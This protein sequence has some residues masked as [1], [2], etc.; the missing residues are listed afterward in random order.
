LAELRAGR[1][2]Q[3]LSL[4]FECRPLPLWEARKRG[5]SQEDAVRLEQHD[6]EGRSAI[7]IVRTDAGTPAAKALRAGDLLV[8]VNGKPVSRVEEVF[9]YSGKE[10]VALDIVR[11]GKRQ[12]V[13]LKTAPD[14][15][16]ASTRFA[17]WA[18][19]LVQPS[20]RALSTQYGIGGDGVYVSR[21]WYGS[22]ADRYGLRATH[23]I[24]SV[25]GET[26]QGFDH[27]LNVVT[28][29]PEGG[30]VRLLTVSLDGKERSVTL[31]LDS[32]YWPTAECRLVNDQWSWRDLGTVAQ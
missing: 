26:V 15:P 22:P 18:G 27:F 28:A 23:R 4:G 19:A 21:F 6:P 5:L 1:R 13:Q 29:P 2:P 12:A 30:T 16:A 20:P 11:L 3:P 25:N 14:R 10:A 8:A 7:T 17:M 32:F 9:S 31:K 24:L